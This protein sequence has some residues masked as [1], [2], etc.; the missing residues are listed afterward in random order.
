MDKISQY[1]S[2]HWDDTVR[3]N[4][5]DFNNVLEKLRV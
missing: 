4:P 1:I 2:D 3:Y 5:I